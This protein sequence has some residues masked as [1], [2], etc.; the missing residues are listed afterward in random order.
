MGVSPFGRMVRHS[1][2]ARSRAV[3]SRAGFS[4]ARAGLAAPFCGHLRP[5]GIEPRP[6][7]LSSEMALPNHPDVCLRVRADTERLRVR[8][9][10]VQEHTVER[11]E[12]GSGIRHPHIPHR[13][14]AAILVARRR[15]SPPSSRPKA[16]IRSWSARCSPT[17]RPASLPRSSWP[18][19]G[20]AARDA[21]CRRR[22][23]RRHDERVPAQV[24]KP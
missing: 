2:G 6:G 4:A 15:V 14:V 12:D 9:V 22:K 13:L 16:A 7:F 3:H 24:L 17:T 20:A 1:L 21:D 18:A 10:L 5:G 19:S 8:W 23:R 11:T